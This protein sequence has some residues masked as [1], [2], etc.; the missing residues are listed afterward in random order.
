MK[1]CE[2]NHVYELNPRLD[3]LDEESGAR[4][5]RRSF[6]SS[7][8]FSDR[9]KKDR[10]IIV[11]VSGLRFETYE[12]TLQRFPET[13]LGSKEKREE[14]Y[15]SAM[16]EYFF[17]RNRSTFEA[18][19]FFYQSKGK[20]VRPNG[21]PFLIFT[22]ELRFF[23]IGREFVQRLEE[24][25][26]YGQK[27]V[28]ILPKNTIQRKI[29]E[30][31]E[32]PDS[33]FGARVLATFSVSIILLSIVVFCIE[34]LP[35]YRCVTN[36]ENVGC[37]RKVVETGRT[38][39]T[40][41]VS[42]KRRADRSIAWFVMEVLCISWFTLEYL[43]RLFSSPHKLLFARSFLNVIDLVAILPYYITLPMENTKITSLAVLRV[44]RLVRVF[45]I[46][47]L[48][49]HSRGLQVLGQTLRASSRELG[50]L[51]FFLFIS[52][53][54][55]A[56]AVYYAEEEDPRSKFNSIPDAF[57]WAVVT[58]TTVGYGDMFPV[59]LWGKIVG[60]I[61]AI[62]G[63]LTIALPVPV[64][65][66]NFNYFYKREQLASSLDLAENGQSPY[67][68][69]CEQEESEGDMVNGPLVSSPSGQIPSPTNQNTYN[70]EV[71]VETPV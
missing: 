53:I 67:A 68:S 34:T 52:V 24:E 44:I 30:L 50:M 55:F 12:N 58:M 65:V 64:I 42:S 62:S 7:S 2:N 43:V 38:N 54:L 61:C 17:D 56:S 14:Y 10:R 21:V 39:S 41:T 60:S 40:T 51:I 59:T 45:R 32:Y 26:G 31:F 63:V 46:F 27:E 22:E 23:E 57:W 69:Y 5:E 6:D 15:D 13:L 8:E 1:S 71:K 66:S 33:S 16:N 25:E 3:K 20:L 35:Q 48:S 49:R 47:K 36:S 29:W 70:L 11:N 19:L 9:Y 28:R 37:E 18:I 4:D